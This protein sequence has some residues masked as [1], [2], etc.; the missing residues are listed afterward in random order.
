M[1]VENLPVQEIAELFERNPDEVEAIYLE[2]LSARQDQ[3]RPVP[4]IRLLA[5]FSSLSTASVS[6]YLRSKSGSISEAKA[7]R[8]AK[9]IDLLEYVPSSA[10]QSLRGRYTNA[11]GIAAPLSGSGSAFFLEVLSG[12]EQEAD[13]L[14]FQQ[15]IFNIITL[16][17]RN[18]FLNSMPFLGIVDGLIVIGMHVDRNRLRVF[19]RHQLP[20]VSVHNHLDASPVVANIFSDNQRTL[21]ELIANHLIGHHGYRRLALVALDSNNP[22]KIGN[23]ENF[24]PNRLA[25]IDAYKQALSQ[26]GIPFDERLIHYAKAHTFEEGYKAF[27]ELNRLNQNLPSEERIQAIVCT[28][29]TLAAGVM[30]AA[31]REKIDIV[32]TG[33]DNLPIAELMNIT[34]VDQR[35]SDIGRH[36]FRHLYNGLS[37]LKRKGELPTA[38]TE[39]I[40]MHLVIRS[41]CGC[42]S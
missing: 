5:A 19:D 34:T 4:D 22:L 35:A 20:V 8:L 7:Q 16:D 9:L 18:D 31:R 39:E 29:D 1:S 11:V 26:N 13:V 6:N 21:Q 37:F 24:D 23:Q 42:V 17:S 40:R 15:F 36:A 33:F 14:G 27:N 2:W 10:A 32:V 41:S 25:R 3:K 38:V 12:I 28:S 30:T